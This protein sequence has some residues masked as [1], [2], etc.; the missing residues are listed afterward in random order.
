MSQNPIGPETL[1]AKCRGTA[2]AAVAAMEWFAANP[3]TVRQ[4]GTALAREFRKFQNTGRRLLAAVER[5]MCVG[6]F[7][8]SQ[9]GKSYLISALARAGTKPLIAEFDGLPAGLDFVRH[10]NPEGGQ[11]ATG[12]VTRFSIKSSPTPA[13][14]P[15][16]LRLLSQTDVVKILGNTYFSDCDLSEEEALT[17]EKVAS[18]VA[19]ARAAAQ[20]R[21]VDSLTEDDVWDLQEYFER[22]FK[23]EDTIKAL[24]AG[25]FWTH[26]A[27][28]APC[29]K[30]SD[31]AR[32]L[33][34]LWGEIEPFTRLFLS[35]Y[36]ALEQ[37]GFPTDAYCA[38]E[39]LV[40][41]PGGAV[42]R[43]TDSIIDVNTLNGLGGE[44]TN[45]LAVSARGGRPV[46]LPRSSVTALVA[47]LRITMRD[48]PW[49]FFEH[50]DLLDFP[51]ARSREIIPDIRRFLKQ[52]RSLESLFLRG[53]VAYLFERYCAEQELTSML[54]CIGPSN[55]EVRT[56]PGIV[57]EWIDL[58]H[59]ADPAARAANQTALFLVL[60]KF[61]AEFAEAA[62]Q[63]ES[64]EA[65]WSARLNAS[66]L[67]FFGKVHD[68]PFRW[69]P[70]KPFDNSY[71]LRNPNFKAKHILEYGA[72][73][74]E[75]GLR[76]SEAARIARSREEYVGNPDVKAHF[77]D[78][79]KAWDEAFRL[80]DG[81]VTYLA[82]SLSPVCS[83]E[84][85]LRQIAG[86]LGHQ[87]AAMH[88]RLS[89]YFVGGD[90]AEQRAKRVGRAEE[91]VKALE[92]CAAKQRFAALLLELQVRDGEL[93]DILYRVETEVS[94][95]TSVDLSSVD[96]ESRF[97]DA[98]VEYW[99]E[100]VR[101]LPDTAP[102][103]RYFLLS[104]AIAQD[105]A[106]E[107]T[108]GARRLDL[109][110]TIL[111]RLREGRNVRRRLGESISKPALLAAEIVNAYVSW[112]GF[113]PGKPGDRPTVGQ[114]EGARKIFEPAA[115]VTE[116]PQL[117]EDPVN[118]DQPFFQDWRAGFLRLV[119]EN[120]MDQGGQMVD[121][122][123]NGRL[124]GIL[125]SL[126]SG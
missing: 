100:R 31:R 103:C 35:L 114:G 6:V 94:Q 45:R 124:G 30:S 14:F 97:A 72:D 107:L 89:R 53:K 88:E 111:Q 82:E 56:L 40:D 26:A 101:T 20:P 63:S 64:S 75:T 122:E 29:L 33:G 16:E 87:R 104:D 19:S 74:L 36:E 106:N 34:V 112:L 86:R 25:G 58:T 5:P 7:G 119:D 13:G 10:I 22:R 105:L 98:I 9:S 48:K 78:P 116:M 126:E 92:G 77:R 125:K 11:E 2:E 38:I 73:G 60:T 117:R 1:A 23:G 39:A 83:P 123:Q 80:N 115:L 46:E 43:R 12:L 79:G 90:L 37:L 76:A 57:K 110:G 93:A 61:D 118:Y 4:E 95:S 15:V 44:V 120:A 18:L 85:K 52:P 54:L 121:I 68:W 71:W 81:G 59:G 96:R 67:G 69:H 62:G 28:L 113:E 55:Q 102:M 3:A 32:L 66:L 21:P 41:V 51:G 49:A 70:D 84:I 109:R 65:R 99:L 47:E 24:A 8:P 17:A 42:S 50:T 108:A 27:E 91:I